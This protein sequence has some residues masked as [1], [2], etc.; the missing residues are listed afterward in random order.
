V[1]DPTVD[2]EQLLERLREEHNTLRWGPLPPGQ[3]RVIEED[4][5]SRNRRSLEY[6]HRHWALP[7]K[8]DPAS[9]GAGLRGKIIG[10]FGRLTFRVLGPY[11]REE[12]EL[13]AHLVQAN[14][15]LEQRCD[16]LTVRCEE[17][18]QDMIDR[19]AAEAEN[20]AKLAVWLHLEAPEDGGSPTSASA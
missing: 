4:S 8:F 17:L 1:G 10:V 19:Q 11:L 14:Q 18:S 7:D 15:A 13:L 12:R 20:Q 16:N 9:S 5:Q 2:P 3:L 6:L